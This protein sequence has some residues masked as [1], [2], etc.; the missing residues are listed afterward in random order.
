MLPL[1]GPLRAY[2][3]ATRP[4]YSICVHDG[5]RV[6][7]GRCVYAIINVRALQV[8]WLLDLLRHRIIKKK[9]SQS[10]ADVVPSRAWLLLKWQ[11]AKQF[12]PNPAR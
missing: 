7:E 4:L 10:Q 11:T 9:S 6:A 5:R 1:S 12:H 8:A 2:S 3:G